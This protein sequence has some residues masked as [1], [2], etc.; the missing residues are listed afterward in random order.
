M[1]ILNGRMCE[2]KG[3]GSFTCKNTSVVDYNIASPNFLKLVQNFS[4]LNSSVLFSDIHN[5]LSLKITCYEKQNDVSHDDEMP[6]EKIKRWENEQLDTFIS[7]IDRLKVNEILAQLTEMVENTSENSIINKVVEDDLS[8]I[9]SSI[10]GENGVIEGYLFKK[11]SKGFKSWVRRLQQLFSIPGNDHCCDCGSK[12]PRWASLNLGIT[13]CIECS[14][15]HRSIRESWIKAKYVQK[16]FVMKLPN[17]KLS[18]E[19]NQRMESKLNLTGKN[20]SKAISIESSDE[21]DTGV[22]EGE[23]SQSTTSWEDMSK[24]DPN[25]LL[26]KAAQARNL[27]VMLEALANGADPNWVNE[28]EEG[29]TPLMK[30]VE[31]DPLQIAVD[32]AN[33]DIVTLLRL[34]KLNEQMKEDSDMGNTDDTFNEVFRDF[35]NMASNN[36]ELLRRHV[37]QTDQSESLD[38]SVE[39]S[40]T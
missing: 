32:A 27:T 19:E 8:Q 12:D 9:T 21:S 20:N 5:P 13:L 17:L 40:P 28:E 26:Y 3:L 1:F 33:A 10:H 7:N 4:V 15:I 34:A 31:T 36:P 22:D 25:M 23:D 37:E 11:T 16:A 29:R 38:S 2:D 6:E 35:S 30:A 39:Q 24:L 18:R 14:G